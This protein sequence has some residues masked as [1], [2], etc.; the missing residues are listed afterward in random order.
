M[1]RDET[2]LNQE[3][4]PRTFLPEQILVVV[5]ALNEA[6]SIE[7]CL[8]SL[9]ASDPF[10]Q[11]VQIVVADG[12]SSDETRAIVKELAEVDP[13][14]SLI[15]NPMRIQSAAV[16][17]AV[18]QVARPCHR[19]LVRC[20]AHAIYPPGYVRRIVEVIAARPQVASV[21]SVMDAV[22]D[23]PFQRASAWIVDTPLGSGG[24]AHRGGMRSG[25]VDHGHHAGFVLDWFRRIGGYDE[26]FSHN[27]DAEFDRRLLEAGGRIWMDASIRVDYKMRRT[28]RALMRQYWNY[29][30][31]RGRTVLKHRIRPRL[32]Q[33]IPALNLIGMAGSSALAPV[34]PVALAWPISYLILLVAVSIFAA[35]SSRDLT[36][37][38]AGVVLGIAHNAWGAGFLRTMASPDAWRAGRRQSAGTLG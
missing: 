27:E 36:G 30:R 15:D 20:D 10:M 17:R 37:L 2:D 19:V 22:G 35:V 9:R 23:A 29:G 26:S 31:G 28:P 25:W 11:G 13:H 21:V 6:R 4:M 3:P 5:P 38:W 34:F 1:M 18:Q 8:H 16:N 7:A 32:R 24:A 33:I 12:G 14:L